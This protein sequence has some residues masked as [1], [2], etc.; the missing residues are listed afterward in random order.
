MA[1]A[2]LKEKTID[3][4]KVRLLQAIDKFYLENK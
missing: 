3:D 4:A 2:Q 1:A